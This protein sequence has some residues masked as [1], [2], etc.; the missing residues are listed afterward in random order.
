VPKRIARWGNKHPFVTTL[1][2]IGL[3][4]S[5]LAW[6]QQHQSSERDKAIAHEAAERA[7]DLVNEAKARADQVAAAAAVAR[8]EVC[9]SAVTAVTG[10]LNNDLLKVIETIEGRIVEQGRPVP[11]IYIQLEDLIRNRQPPLEACEPKENP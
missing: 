7:Q 11:P 10:Q 9:K 8:T 3:F 1:I 2:S 6:S 5:L 4:A